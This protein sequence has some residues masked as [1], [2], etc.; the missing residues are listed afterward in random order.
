VLT[1]LLLLCR[2]L[3]GFRLVSDAHYGGIIAVTCL[4]LLSRPVFGFRLV[5]DAHHGGIIAATG[6][7]LLQ[8]FLDFVNRHADIVIVTNASHA[9]HL[10]RIGGNAFVCPDPL[11]EIPH[12][13]AVSVGITI[14]DKSVLF[15]CTYDVDEPYEAVFEA[16]RLL[17][18]QGF[19][20]YVSGNYRRVGLNPN[21]VPQVSLLG[22]VD[23]TVYDAYL[24]NVAVVLDLTSCEDCLVCGGYE[25]MA[26]ETPCVLSETPALTSLFTHG[27]VFTSHDPGSIAGAVTAA[28][29]RREA[30]RAEIVRWTPSHDAAI[31]QS[32]AELRCALGLDPAR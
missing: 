1:C 10:R 13:T 7:R 4:L 15:V 26:A 16:A 8:H 24:R 29:E 6:D 19:T 21:D 17:V 20:V 12:D 28:Y 22:F 9:E 25:A 23:R 14:P 18:T 30:L 27:A 11:P 32:A 5:S 2:P 31:R 3:F